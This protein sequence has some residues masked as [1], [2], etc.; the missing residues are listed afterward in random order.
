MSSFE[1][2]F[3]RSLIVGAI[4]LVLVVYKGVRPICGEAI[5][6]LNSFCS[7][8][9]YPVPQAL[10]LNV[11]C[12]GASSHRWHLLARGFLGFIGLSSGYFAISNM[13]LADAT[14]LMFTAPVW[15]VRYCE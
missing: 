5:R 11:Q 9:L 10:C 3:M 15:T 12:A 2:V 8:V 13:Q 1:I 4:G 7:S 6:Q 14:V